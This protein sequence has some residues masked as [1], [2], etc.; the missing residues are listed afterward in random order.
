V[1]EHV[2]TIYLAQLRKT[3]ESLLSEGRVVYPEICLELSRPEA[4]REI[5]RL[6]VVDIL[7]RLPDGETSVVEV[8]VEPVAVRGPG[9]PVDAPIAWN[10]VEFRCAEDSFPE[11][12]LAA[13]GVRWVTDESPPMG[14][15]DGFTG[16]IHSV[17]EPVSRN[18]YVEFSVD[19]GSAPI[20]AFDELMAILG[21]SLRSIGSYSLT[22]DAA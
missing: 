3:L 6:Y 17:A 19:F 15:Q 4:Q 20:A 22:A 21:S 2:R 9:L 7:E 5:Y 14:P 11:P 12:G 8:N 18:S 10:G 1:L 16:I 13:W